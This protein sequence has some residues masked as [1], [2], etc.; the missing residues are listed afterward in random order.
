MVVQT[1]TELGV[2][3]LDVQPSSVT[4]DLP[5]GLVGA[6][7]D[8]LVEHL[9][10]LEKLSSKLDMNV[11]LEA[12]ADIDQNKPPNNIT[13]NRIDNAAA[14]NQWIN[15]WLHAIEAKHFM[16]IS[17]RCNPNYLHPSARTTV[18]WMR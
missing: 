4:P 12:L 13:K 10:E 8:Q 1:L 15:G 17:W 9:G 11:P 3:F 14:E 5:A 7:V 2:C 6:R 16:S 18:N